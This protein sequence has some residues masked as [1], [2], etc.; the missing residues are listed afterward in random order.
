MYWLANA[1]G[2]AQ[3][4]HPDRYFDP[5]PNVRSLAGKLYNKVKDIPILSPHGHIE[6][7]WFAQNEPFADP[8]QTLVL[9]DHYVLRLLYSQGI[10]L[11][12]LG[13]KPL[14]GGDFEQD[15]K[16][17]WK[18]FASHYYL[19]D[20]TPTGA[21]LDFE[22]HHL[23]GIEERLD[24]DNALAIYE[25]INEELKAKSFLPRALFESFNVEVLST[26]NGAT[27]ALQHHIALKTSG[28]KGR[29]LP[30]FRPDDVLNLNR[31]DWAHNIETLSEL[32]GKEITTHRNFIAALQ[33]RRAFF[34]ELGAVSTDHGVECAHT[35][36]LSD[37]EASDIF[38]RALQ[39]EASADD[40]RRFNA[41]MLMEMARMSLQ[42]G[43]VMQIHP[44]SVR[45]HN[46]VL[47][48]R[49]GP[50][51]GADIPSTTD[52]THGLH[53]LLNKYGNE[54]HFHLIV[55]TLDE[56]TYSRELAPLAGH[57]PAM[58][59][60]PAWWFHDSFFGMK[61][62][63]EMIWE[64]A[65]IYNTVGFIDDTR[66]LLS[67]PARHELA[68]RIDCNHIAGLVRHHILDEEQAVRMLQALT[69]DLSKIAYRL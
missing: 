37:R 23:F 33:E 7:S 45:N 67:I 40:N 43:L 32:T 26:T 42:D 24:G 55:F 4:L 38:A 59:V 20:G 53:A 12:K 29:I 54:K 1:M 51:K 44:G 21:W 56:S 66:A 10:P 46:A 28:W 18:L 60:G 9:P 27:D 39:G 68:R 61:R 52:Y 25:R 11:E 65:S 17:A 16:E 57:Y 3:M 34:Q 64:T 49:F 15:P 48:R 69:Y 2:T 47:Y 5:D 14:D 58:R 6:A 36:E 31:P 13:V 62:F 8:M 50:D 22:F 19:F 41:H 63:R 35:E 30:C